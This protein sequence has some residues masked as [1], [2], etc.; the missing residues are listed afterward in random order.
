M[1]EREKQLEKLLIKSDK[2]LAERDA[3]I[4]LLRQK[5]DLLIRRVFGSSSEKLDPA[6]LELLLG[7]EEL[8]KSEASST[9]EEPPEEAEEKNAKGKRRSRRKEPRLP[10]DLPVLV[11]RVITPEEVLASPEAWVKIGEDHQDLLDVI[12]ASYYKQRIINE[13]YRSKADK[14]RPPVQSPM[15]P[16]PIPG[17]HC[18]PG[19]AASLIV[20]KYSDHLPHY[21][22]AGILST[23]QNIHLGRNTLNRWNGAIAARLVPVSAAIRRETLASDYLQID[24]TPIRYL[25]PGH[26]RTKQGYLWIYQNPK[27]NIVAYQWSDTRSHEAPLEWLLESS[28]S[29]HIQCDGYK[30]YLT[31]L[32]KLPSIKLAACLAH[33]RRKIKEA[34]ASAPRQAALL[35]KLIGHLYRIEE[36]LRQQRAGPNLRDA[37]RSSQSAP[38]YKRLEKI[39]R[40]LHARHLPQ[41]PLRKALNYALG[42]WEQQLEHLHHGHIEIDNNLAENA[43]RPTK[44]GMKNWLFFGNVEAGHMSAAIYT[45]IENCKRQGLNPE[46]YLKQVLEELPHD[47]TDEQAAKFTPSAIAR[48]Q[49][50][51]KTA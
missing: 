51:C 7:S 32:G 33:I 13:K 42:Q 36:N 34:T 28:F 8:G 20:A 14:T 27:S 43:V 15:P 35:L 39:I 18:A 41:H 9:N 25:A 21:R 30:A 49:K 16:V 22:Q 23:R 2:K 24:E 5:L 38:I 11:T 40:I 6:Q 12:P 17:T 44:L 48:K 37:V 50:L 31:L 1:T 46:A 4:K 3:E 29:G 19:L 47:S 45:I 10:K 26:G